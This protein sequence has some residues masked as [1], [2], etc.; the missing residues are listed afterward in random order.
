MKKALSYLVFILVMACSF[1]SIADGNMEPA[2]AA[3]KMAAV[4]INTASVKELMKLPGIGKKKAMA[5]VEYRE[6]NG[7]FS[8]VEDLSKVEGVGKRVAK[9]LHDKVSF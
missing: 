9:A 8:S 1:T 2:K 3:S 5:I 7:N 6:K 4:N